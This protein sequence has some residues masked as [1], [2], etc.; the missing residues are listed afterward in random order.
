MAVASGKAE[1]VQVLACGAGGGRGDG[2]EKSG[3]GGHWKV[4]RERHRELANV[5]LSTLVTSGKERKRR[6]KGRISQEQLKYVP[7]V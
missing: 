4:V 1:T 6:E 3:T 5:A 7:S 2:E